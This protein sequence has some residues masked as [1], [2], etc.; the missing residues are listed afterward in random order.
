MSNKPS[1]HHIL[2]CKKEWRLRPAGNRLRQTHELVP[3]L[4]TDTHVAL[5]AA[6]SQVPLLAFHSL[7]RVVARFEPVR[8][9]TMATIDGLCF[10]IAE[11]VNNPNCRRIEQQMGI[12]AIEAIREQVPFIQQ[13]IIIPRFAA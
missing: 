7:E 10:N 4:D 9:D 6:T 2:H 3:E 1:R 11:A 5:H 13:G 12:L 8:G